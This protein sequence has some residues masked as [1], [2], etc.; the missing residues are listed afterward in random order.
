M[1]LIIG[2]PNKVRFYVPDTVSTASV[3]FTKDDLTDIQ[4]V[5]PVDNI[6]E[7]TVPY[8]F[9][10][11]PGFLEGEITFSVGSDSYTSTR[12]WEV[13]KPY[14]ELFELKELFP[15]LSES[16]LL[17]LEASARSTINAFCGQD[18]GFEKDVIY[19]AVGQG[20]TYLD[21]PKKIVTLKS[22]NGSTDTAQYEIGDY[23]IYGGEQ[24]IGI[25][26]APPEWAQE[27]IIRYPYVDNLVYFEEHK[28]YAVEGDWGF[29]VVPTE[30][31]QAMKTLM[32]DFT[33]KENAM[34]EKGIQAAKAADWSLTF[35]TGVSGRT[36]TTG[37]SQ[38]DRLLSNFV[39]NRWV[40]V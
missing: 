30:V 18:F 31:M 21:L 9:L 19:N 4:A 10:N 32:N 1:E 5:S 13:V 16:E 27:N 33:S 20:Q 23:V 17:M 38:V 40:V 34:K 26:E 29:K 28:L 12:G 25:K 36:D 35:E 7:V 6:V 2:G 11:S 24:W 15:T 14:V 39:A 22:I 3:K 37:N 8:Q